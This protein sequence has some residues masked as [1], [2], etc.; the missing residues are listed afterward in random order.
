MSAAAKIAAA[1]ASGYVLGRTKKLRL[2]VTVAG[3]LAG[4]KIATDPRGLAKQAMELI[5]S[6]PELSKLSD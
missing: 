2:A 6:N 1:V 4:K 3:M 5:E